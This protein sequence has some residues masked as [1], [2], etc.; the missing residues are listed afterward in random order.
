MAYS[1]IDIGE[2]DYGVMAYGVM[3]AVQ[4]GVTT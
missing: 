2:M 4:N 3:V 1:V